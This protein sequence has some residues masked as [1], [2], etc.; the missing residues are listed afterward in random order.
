MSKSELISVDLLSDNLERLFALSKMP[1][2]QWLE[3]MGI[4]WKNYYLYKV[5]LSPLPF[6][7]LRQVA[8]HFQV[9]QDQI[10]Q[11]PLDFNYLES[12]LSKDELPDRYQVGAHGRRRTTITSVEYLEKNFGWR[13]KYDV[14][15]QIDVTAAALQDPFKKISMQA[16]TDMTRFLKTRQFNATDFFHMGLYSMEGNKNS[17]IGKIYSQMESVEQAYLFFFHKTLSLF[18]SNCFYAYQQITNTTG[19]V[20]VRSSPDV[21][22]ELK[23]KHLGNDAICEL[24][25]GMFASIPAYMGLP[26]AVITHFTCEHKGDDACRYHIDYSPCLAH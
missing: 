21:A 20:V 16:I 22:A 24:K 7:S 26:N 11:A 4:S 23:V 17:L 6:S 19:I 8:S 5:G 9:S 13:L 14:L 25:A 10:S 15:N 2:N 1:K 12:I 18:E 3:L